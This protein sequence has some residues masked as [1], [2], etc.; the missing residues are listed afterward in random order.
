M[1]HWSQAGAHWPQYWPAAP[2]K[3]GYKYVFIHHIYSRG[4]QPEM[5]FNT[6][7]NFPP[8]FI[9]FTYTKY[10][11]FFVLSTSRTYSLPPSFIPFT[12]STPTAFPAYFHLHTLT[13]FLPSSFIYSFHLHHVRTFL[14]TFHLHILTQFLLFSFSH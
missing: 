5:F 14:R 4:A 10:V 1:G 2:F 12:T 6:Y 9:P 7:I 11:L 3:R 13:Q 8:S